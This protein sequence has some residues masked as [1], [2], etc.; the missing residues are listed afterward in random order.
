MSNTNQTTSTEN[1]SPSSQPRS[2]Y[3]KIVKPLPSRKQAMLFPG[4]DDVPILDY[5]IGVGRL[6]GPK[7]IL[8]ASKISKKRIC[9]YL[10][11]EKTVDSFLSEHKSITINNH[12]IDARKL[13]ASS[14]KLILSNVHSCIPNSL[15][16]EELQK[17]HIKTTSAIFDLHIG[18]SSDKYDKSELELYTH[19]SSFRRGV[20]IDCNDE[21]KI[22]E[23]LLIQF[24]GEL[25]RIF[26]NENELKCHIC[27]QI[28]HNAAQCLDED[29]DVLPINTFQNHADNTTTTLMNPDG[30]ELKKRPLTISDTASTTENC[31]LVD[32]SEQLDSIQEPPNTSSLANRKPK[33]RRKRSHSPSVQLETT[34]ND[35]NSESNNLS[36]RELLKSAEEKI[37]ANFQQKRYNLNFSN[38]LLLLD[39]VKGKTKTEDIKLELSQFTE[40][41]PNLELKN[42]YTLLIDNYKLVP[43][44]MKCRFTKLRKHILAIQ[45]D[46]A[47][48]TP[49]SK[50]FSDLDSESSTSEDQDESI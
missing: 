19:I 50:S 10:V 15:I 30:T 26:M 5:I 25:F 37:T 47:K 7:K 40:L 45:P 9:I 33:K 27:K 24:E 6:I 34:H 38:F 29:I 35:Q 44:I 43:R 13:V 42:I 32:I 17:N 41:I 18:T 39:A 12:K 48:Q 14:R 28:G 11:D 4:I 1:M 8:S 23:S 49:D 22:P 2:T 21:T 36:T 3:A 20:Y 31:S 46:L 16:L